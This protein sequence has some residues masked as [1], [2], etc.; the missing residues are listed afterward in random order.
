MAAIAMSDGERPETE[1]P[2]A[3][4][5]KDAIDPELV[6][7]RKA[8]PPIGAVTAFGVAALCTYLVVRLIPDIA[9]SR[10]DDKPIAATVATIGERVNQ[11]VEVDAELV[12]SRAVR[13]RE[14]ESVP[15][16]RVVPIVGTG[17]RAWIVMTGGWTAEVRT[18]EPLAGRV[19]EIDDLPIAD[20]LRDYVAGR[21][22]PTFATLA[23]A[24]AAFAGGPLAT[25]TGERVTV[26]PAERVELDVPVPDAALV[27]A[28]FNSRL[29]DAAA[30]TTALAD[31]GVIAPGAAPR[32]VTANTASYD[33]AASVAVTTEKL[34]KAELFAA[35]VEPVNRTL[36]TTWGELARSG[37]GPLVVAGT[38]VPDD[39]V[40]LVRVM[41]RRT[42]PAGALAIVVGERPSDYWYMLPAA[43]GLGLLAAL[44]MWAL[45]RAIRRDY[46]RPRSKTA[47]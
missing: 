11:L 5:A 38:P 35:R 7:L 6:N 15:G 33:V 30:W 22:W 40:D 9:F 10:G 12:M 3:P 24:R 1:Q 26:N 4:V 46:L 25:V 28:T 2:G 17:D 39:R 19:R 44:A 23:S 47:G 41:T 32:E 14:N 31:A 21:T 16:L 34:Q 37:A 20:E 27:V 13:L 43:I 29:S 36:A 45:V 42:I 18:I 8:R